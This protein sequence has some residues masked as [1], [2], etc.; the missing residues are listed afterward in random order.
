MTT[1]DKII[2]KLPAFIVRNEVL[3]DLLGAVGASIDTY[4]ST[5]DDF[6][7]AASLEGGSSAVLDAIAADYGLVRHYNDTDKI[8]SIRLMNAI[9]T[10][11]QRGSQNGLEAEGAEISLVTPY[12][13]EMRYAVGVNPIGTGWAL[14]GVGAQWMQIWN[15]T[16]GLE[17]DIKDQ[18]TQILPIHLK[19]GQDYL[20][21]FSDPPSFKSVIGADLLDEDNFTIVNDG[22][23]NDVNTL[24]PTQATATY[25]YGNIDL[26]A[27]FATY[28]WLV[29]WIDYVAWD[30]VYDLIAQARFSSDEISWSSWTEYHRNQWVGGAEIERYAQFKIELTMETYRSLGHYIFRSFVLKGLTT[31]QQLYGRPNKAIAANIL[32]GN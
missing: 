12:N 28:Q 13:Q 2:S 11:Q 19:A 14:G 20:D 21:A 4:L 9:Q 27:G 10:Y 25:E 17:I 6:A 26:G 29:D 7:T 30:V 24:I 5:A 23:A 1:F 32:V 18:I 22:F 15:D 31:D 16:P 8:M 3:S